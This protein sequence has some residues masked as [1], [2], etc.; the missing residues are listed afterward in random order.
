MQEPAAP[1]DENVPGFPR[2]TRCRYRLTGPIEQCV[3]CASRELNRPDQYACEICDQAL[4]PAMHCT[5]RLCQ[6]RWR[7]QFTR[8]HAIGLK[9]RGSPLEQ[10]IHRY[11]YRSATGWSLIFARLLLGWLEQT[12]DPAAIDLIVA[13]PTYTGPPEFRAAHTEAVIDS[14][15]IQDTR[16]LWPFDQQQPR[17]IVA[18]G[19]RPQ[20]AGGNLGAKRASAAVLATVLL[21]PEASRIV[22]RHVLVYDDVLTSGE[23]M[24]AV[25]RALRAAGAAKVTGVVLARQIWAT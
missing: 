2:C 7:R 14:A 13:S 25:A 1:F 24:N 18:T 6:E 16:R 10:T 5:N 4:E 8:V 9:E 17:A 21:I 22:G 19:P 11:K 3:T 20:S 23:T 12:M 15:A